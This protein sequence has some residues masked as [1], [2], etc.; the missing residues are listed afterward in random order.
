MGKERIVFLDY[1]GVVR[2]RFSD[3]LYNTKEFYE[4]PAFD[5]N[6]VKVLAK[7]QERLS[8]KFVCSSRAWAESDRE[9]QEAKFRYHGVNLEFHRDFRTP[10]GTDFTVEEYL[11]GEHLPYASE[12]PW[13]G[14]EG[15]YDA[16]KDT[17]LDE[18]AL[19]S[20][21]VDRNRGFC[22]LSWLRKHPE[23]GIDD[24]M[25]IDDES[26]IFPIR[27]KNFI[28]V[29]QGESRGGFGWE[30]VIQLIEFFE[31]QTPLVEVLRDMMGKN[32][33]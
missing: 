19:R 3:L 32:K 24:F 17:T 1:D 26:D 12:D 6:I 22:I 14:W 23:I 5:V 30:Y 21:L 28:H 18:M 25:V 8:F 20:G 4:I 16:Y 15:Y 29:Q 27:R 13:E 33:S 9:T 10:Y 2:H 31:P 11:N 7:L